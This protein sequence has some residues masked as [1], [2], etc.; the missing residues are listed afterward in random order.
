MSVFS[1]A[2]HLEIKL[3]IIVIIV[4]YL[5]AA[6]PNTAMRVKLNA[7]PQGVAD[8]EV[9]PELDIVFSTPHY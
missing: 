6:P 3:I 8:A 7:G 5:Q 1:V 9:L 4:G 2:Y